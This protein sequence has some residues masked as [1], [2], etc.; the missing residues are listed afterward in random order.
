MLYRIGSCAPF[1]LEQPSGMRASERE[2]VMTEF[3]QPA[4]RS[5]RSRFSCPRSSLI[6]LPKI[7][8]ILFQQGQWVSLQLPVGAKPP[9]NCA[10][11]IGRPS[12]PW[13]QLKHVDDL[14]LSAPYGN[15]Q[16]LL[17]LDRD[18]L[19]ISRYT[20]LVSIRGIL[21]WRAESVALRPAIRPS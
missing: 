17:S 18:L 13:G 15:F 11:S 20:R 4:K 21:K 7:Q 12:F 1:H 2:I 14:Q 3:I 8:W 6:L 19:L 16:S 5:A 10:S 9:I